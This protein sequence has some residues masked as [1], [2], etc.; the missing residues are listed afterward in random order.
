MEV[1]QD[2]K[3]ILAR[4]LE[5]PY[6]VPSGTHGGQNGRAMWV[7]IRCSLPADL[8]QEWLG[9]LLPRDIDP[10]VV[11]RLDRPER[12]RHAYPIQA[13]ARDL[14]DV[15]LGDERIV[16][17]LEDGQQLA[18]AEERGAERPLVDCAW[19][20]G[21]GCGLHLLEERGDDER[22]EDKEPAK[23]HAVNAIAAP[24][25]AGAEGGRPRVR[26]RAVVERVRRVVHP[27]V[28]GMGS[29]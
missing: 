1:E 7:R 12:N 19:A 14:R 24:V 18:A 5:H 16:V 21:P 2:T 9:D 11:P 26:A 25:P 27:C 20:R 17:L 15:L 4:P 23:V 10:D 29:I 8:R 13:R 22:L 6:Y 28:G 3:P